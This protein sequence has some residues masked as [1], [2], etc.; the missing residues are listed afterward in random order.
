M[1]KKTL[2]VLAAVIV[3]VPACSLASGTKTEKG[4]SV[5]FG[6]G[7]A[8]SWIKSDAKGKPVEMGISFPKSAMTGLPPANPEIKVANFDTHLFEMALPRSASAT[9]FT[10]AAMD[11][12]PRGHDPEGV[13]TVPHIDFHF[14]TLTEKERKAIT[15]QGDDLARCKK[16]PEPKYMPAAY[17]QAPGTEVPQM[18]SHWVDTATPELH[19]KPFTYTMI[20]GSYNGKVAFVEPMISREFL[21]AGIEVNAAIAQPKAFQKKGKYYPTRFKLHHDAKSGEIHVILTGFKKR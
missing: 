8:T 10:H 21:E 2:F 14:Y 13:Y 3:G 7:K 18:G 4:P 12:N 6:S 1:N 9:A 19:G 17:I 11:W 20:Y 15:A 16:A 5:S